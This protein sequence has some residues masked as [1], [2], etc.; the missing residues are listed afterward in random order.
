MGLAGMTCM[1]RMGRVLGFVALMIKEKRSSRDAA[2]KK[3]GPQ[4]HC[5][6]AWQLLGCSDAATASE[7]DTCPPGSL[8]H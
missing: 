7:T 3:H 1:H 5:T 8:R 6:L 2:S 4:S